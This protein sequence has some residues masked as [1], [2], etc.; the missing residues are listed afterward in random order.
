VRG[1]APAGGRAPPL[2][3]ARRG[4][5]RGPRVRVHRRRRR[6]PRGGGARAG[7]S[8]LR[9]P[10]SRRRGRAV[11]SGL[12]RHRVRRP[13]RQPARAGDAAG[14][15]GPAGR[16][17]ACVGDHGVRSPLPRRARRPRGLPVLVRDLQGQGVR[18][19]RR[20]GMPHADRPR[21]PQA[22]RLQGRRAGAVP[23]EL[24]GRLRRCLPEL[25][26]PRRH[27][28]RADVTTDDAAAAARGRGARGPRHRFRRRSR[29]RSP[30]REPVGP[31]G[32]GNRLAGVGWGRWRPG[33]VRLGGTVGWGRGAV[34][35]RAGS[36]H[37][38]SGPMPLPGTVVVLDPAGML[39]RLGP[40]DAWSG[41]LGGERCPQFRVGACLTVGA[42]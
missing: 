5:V 17:R 35:S 2:P 18:L 41:R 28:A 13:L 16:L 30:A 31:P 25:A 20:C 21:A 19:D 12:F 10:A 9:G 38:G 32:R 1:R 36:W 26:L 33:P 40:I 14:V 11:A 34:G 4:T 27:V 7:T 37:G 15:P 29:R 24:P 6:R 22:R 39:R 8:R 3:G 42:W 23:H